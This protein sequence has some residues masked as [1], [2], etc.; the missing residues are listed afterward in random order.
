MSEKQGIL[1]MRP[2]G[3]LGRGKGK[4]RLATDCLLRNRLS[5][6]AALRMVIDRDPEGAARVQVAHDEANYSPIC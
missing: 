1:R 3:S 4:G 6:Q 2:S 5:A